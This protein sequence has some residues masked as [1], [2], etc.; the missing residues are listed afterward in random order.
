M[1]R[2]TCHNIATWTLR[3]VVVTQAGVNSNFEITHQPTGLMIVTHHGLL[4]DVGTENC[5][6]FDLTKPPC[7]SART[8]NRL[9]KNIKLAQ[10]LHSA[11]ILIA[12][13]TGVYLYVVSVFQSVLKKHA[14]GVDTTSFFFKKT[15]SLTDA[16]LNRM[17]I[18]WPD[19]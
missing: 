19:S 6:R 1:Q 18:Q 17:T 8:E 14:D 3:T 15:A 7:Q 2:H 4:T 5:V 13:L 11:S 12:I 10:E 16:W 9:W